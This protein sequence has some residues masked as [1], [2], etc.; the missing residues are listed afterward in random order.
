MA[1][2]TD[3]QLVKISTDGLS[4][5]VIPTLTSVLILELVA[6]TFVQS[7]Y[8]ALQNNRS[9]IGSFYSETPTK[10]L[11]NGN[12]LADGKSVQNTFENEIPKPAHYEAQSFDCQIINQSYPTPTPSGPKQPAQTTIKDMSILVVVSGNVRY[13]DRDQ[14]QRGFSETFVLVPNPSS[15]TG[16]RGK[17]RRFDHLI[18]SQNF[19]LVV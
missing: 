11:F 3:D 9:S 16:D 15:G 17:V 19:R 1:Q 8:S 18:E 13:G 7:Y 4:S 14:P 12:I 2:M 10:L 6:T 5:Q